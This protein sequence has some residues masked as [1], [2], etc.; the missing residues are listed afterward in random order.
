MREEGQPMY[1]KDVPFGGFDIFLFGDFRQLPPLSARAMYSRNFKSIKTLRKVWKTTRRM[2]R[3]GLEAYYEINQVITLRV[4]ERQRVRRKPGQTDWQARKDAIRARNFRR[5]LDRMGNGDC[6]GKRNVFDEK[7]HMSDFKWWR[8]AML[9]DEEAVEK[10]LDDDRVVTL[11][12]TNQEALNISAEY[13]VRQCAA[14]NM[15]LWQWSANNTWR[16]RA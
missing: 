1:K 8:Q 6:S 2:L 5:H 13:A 12:H 3:K 7:T 15:H 11:V 16:G 14:K 10:W 9:T 4:N